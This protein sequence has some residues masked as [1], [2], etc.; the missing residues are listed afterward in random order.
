MS[1]SSSSSSS[2]S[3][4]VV[5]VVVVV[6]MVVVFLLV[7]QEFELSDT[8]P[9]IELYEVDCIRYITPIHNSGGFFVP[10]VGNGES[11]DNETKKTL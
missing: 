4:H 6:V 7:I 5:V 11:P 9:V 1:C 2:I 10:E 8:G 3:C